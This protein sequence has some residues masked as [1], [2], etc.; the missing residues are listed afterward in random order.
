MSISYRETRCKAHGL[1]AQ[2]IR[3]PWVLDRHGYV[4]PCF[5]DASLTPSSHREPRGSH[6]VCSVQPERRVWLPVPCSR[7]G[8]PAVTEATR[9]SEELRR[10]RGARCCT[11]ENRQRAEFVRTPCREAGPS[12]RAGRGAEPVP[13]PSWTLAA[14]TVGAPCFRSTSVGE[15]T[16]VGPAQ[17]PN[18]S[19]FPSRPPRPERLSAAPQAARTPRRYLLN[20]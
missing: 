16:C 19:F 1:L 17:P 11:M 15:S 13:V 10:S 5:H 18:R 8:P 9:R 3:G 4:V 6:I 14:G 12:G 7:R 20:K 2:D